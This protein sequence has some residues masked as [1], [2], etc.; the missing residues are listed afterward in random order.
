MTVVSLLLT[1]LAFQG[2]KPSDLRLVEV[3][4]AGLAVSVPKTWGQN[5]K[6]GTLSASLKV[7]ITDSKLFGKME[8][9]YVVDES[10]DVDDFLGATKSVLTVGG[11]TI[12]RQWKVDIMTSALALTRYSKNGMTT[13]RGVLF[14]PAKNK[15]VISISSETAQ[16]DKVEPYLLSTLESM[17]EVKVIQPKNPTLATEKK[18]HIQR[19]I[20]DSEARLP[21]SQP[22]TVGGRTLF[23]KLPG[24]CKVTKTG[25]ATISCVI[26]G[27]TSSI[28]IVAH[29]SEGNPPS[30]VFQTKAAES[31]KLYKGAI[32]RVD[33]T[34]GD[35][36]DK[37]VRDFIWRTGFSEKDGSP[38][39]TVDCVTTQ[40][41]PIFLA[42]FYS[43]GGVFQYAKDRA[44]L[45]SFL[46]TI[47]LNEK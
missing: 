15:F 32:Q 46:N 2:A 11:N 24:G 25:N 41:A 38:L 40:A 45:A 33:Q 7:P 6:D 4:P 21:L 31:N 5:A 14:R 9:G 47:R 19:V 35:H 36:G 26:P 37:Q 22:V 29:S 34:S 18:I 13:V 12:E 20:T 10:K 28:T 39:M 23:I 43:H 8:I 44:I 1:S 3:K 42:S 30:L 17:R 27:L 16:F